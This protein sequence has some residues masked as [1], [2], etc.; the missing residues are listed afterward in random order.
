MTRV[1]ISDE[2]RGLWGD[3]ILAAVPEAEFVRGDAETG[4]LSVDVLRKPF[5][6]DDLRTA[7]RRALGDP[8]PD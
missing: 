6:V 3:R 4:W 7:V 1:Q 2:A 5:G 8:H